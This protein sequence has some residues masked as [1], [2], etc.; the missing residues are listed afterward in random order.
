MR[1]L[2]SVAFSVVAFGAAGA[3]YAEPPPIAPRPAPTL[4][5]TVTLRDPCTV[6]AIRA[7]LARAA[8]A[9]PS[10]PDAEAARVLARAT[11][12]RTRTASC[13]TAK[14]A[15]A[16]SAA[17]DATTWARA[18]GEIDAFLHALWV[19]SV[20]V[21]SRPD[22]AYL[23]R[24]DAST[25]TQNDIDAGVMVCIFGGA[26]AVPADFTID[27]VRIATASAKRP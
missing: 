18:T 21:G 20:L 23:A 8:A 1:A 13:L 25:T 27:H 7:E 15:W 10:G 11:A 9:V 4:P 17:D 6:D 16:S 14:L 3:A 24:C 26:V 2:L 22:V 19:G 5:R 12:F